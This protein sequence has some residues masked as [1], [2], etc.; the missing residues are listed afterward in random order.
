MV[1]SMALAGAMAASESEDLR[2]QKPKAYELATWA[3]KQLA[4]ASQQVP[5]AECALHAVMSLPGL[6]RLESLVW[7]QSD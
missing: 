2:A 1:R 6:V 3:Q 7:L 4:R 5:L